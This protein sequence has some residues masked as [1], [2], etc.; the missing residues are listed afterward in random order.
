M[1][2]ALN[3]VILYVLDVERLAT[4][5]RDALGLPAIEEIKG[6]WTVLD[7]G[8][9]QLALHRVGAAYRTADPGSWQVQSNAKLVMT[10]DR[11]LAELRAELVAKG[12]PMGELKS[13][14]G[15]TGALCDGKE[16]EAMCFNS[17]RPRRRGYS[18]HRIAFRPRSSI[19]ARLF[20][21]WRAAQRCPSLKAKHIYREERP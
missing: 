1:R 16:P 11:P 15:Y 17:Q 12:I 7:A 10:V 6:E 5:Y 18:R 21:H 19:M 14:P 13:Y 3:R 8:P 9:C 4:F 20:A 2:V